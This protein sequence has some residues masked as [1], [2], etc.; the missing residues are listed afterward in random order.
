MVILQRK[1]LQNRKKL[2]IKT[3]CALVAF[4]LIIS[5]INLYANEVSTSEIKASW[6]NTIIDWLDWRTRSK[7]E[8]NVICAVGRDKV[9][10]YLRRIQLRLEVNSDGN[11]LV[12]NKAPEDDFKECSILYISDSE[13]EYYM[14]ILEKINDHQGI[15]SISSIGGFAKHGGT[16]EFVIRKKA[17][18]IINMTSVQKARVRVDEELSGWVETIY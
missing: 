2:P 13:Q 5:P 18:L 16:I 7:N 4:F 10:M 14:N 8:K 9:Y 12:K 17:R 11:I 15:I 3:C 1:T 6:I